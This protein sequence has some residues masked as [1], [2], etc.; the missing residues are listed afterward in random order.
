MDIR[1]FKEALPGLL[2]NPAGDN[3]FSA[4]RI[5][6]HG[7]SGIRTAKIL[8]FACR[9]MN[10]GEMYVEIGTYSGYTLISAGYQL[11]AKCIGI[12]NFSMDGFVKPGAEA[13]AKTTIRSLLQRNLAEHGTINTQ[14]VE[15]DFRNVEFTDE[16]KGK[17]AVLFID[18]KHT[19]SDVKE[20]M[21][22]FGPYLSKDAVVVFDDVQFGKI[23]AYI[24]ELMAS[25]D[26]EML[27]YSV[28]TVHPH[29]AEVHRHMYLDEYIANGICVM[30]KVNHA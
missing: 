29:D 6:T 15:A 11:N 8:N 17:L 10:M 30:G 3:A 18:G 26:F 24:T 25:G 23:P 1:R 20:T 28:S 14:F 7:M 16:A 21:E 13:E 12:D 2:M 27:A 22:K 19:Y 9:C 4:L 5:A